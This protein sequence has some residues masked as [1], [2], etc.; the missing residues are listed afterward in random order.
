MDLGVPV[1]TIDS[2]VTMRGISSFKGQRSENEQFFN[3]EARPPVKLS[4]E[5]QE[6]FVDEVR[7]SVLFGFIVSYAQGL[8]LL[9]EASE[10]KE[11][12]LNLDGT[13]YGEIRTDCSACGNVFYE[14][15]VLDYFPRFKGDV[16][17]DVVLSKEYFMGYRRHVI[18]SKQFVEFLVDYGS[19]EWGP[20]NLVPVK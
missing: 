4:A 5:D 18:V 20:M 10:E 9:V 19:M 1:P 12:D 11:Y 14:G 7:R 15:N 3:L 8:A 6:R 16:L 17:H 2:A 13:S